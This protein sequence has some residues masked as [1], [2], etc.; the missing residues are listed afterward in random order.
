MI[1]QLKDMQDWKELKAGKFRKVSEKFL[2]TECL[3][4]IY[5]MT[6]IKANLKKLTLD[7]KVGGKFFPT[8]VIGDRIRF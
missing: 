4:E 3:T 7:F 8:W 2:L 5:E 1:C 6:S